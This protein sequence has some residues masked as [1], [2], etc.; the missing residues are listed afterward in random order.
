VG[1]CAIQ[2][3]R[4]YSIPVV[5][6][7]SPLHFD[8]CRSLGAA[9]VFDYHDA[10]VVEK[11]K[12]AAPFIAHAFDCIGSETSSDIASQTVTETGG[13]LCTVRPGKQFTDKAQSRVK[14]TDV[15]VWTVFLK[16]H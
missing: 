2:L 6:V 9:H 7:C 15:L 1:A 5:T 8:L 10:D 4:A 12:S 16:D 3:A 14:V 13:V 11:I